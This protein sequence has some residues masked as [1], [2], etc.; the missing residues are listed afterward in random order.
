M[1][2]SQQQPNVPVKDTNVSKGQEKDT[3]KAAGNASANASALVKGSGKFTI[4]RVRDKIDA[5]PDID[6]ER[7]ASLKA[8]IKSGEYQ[9]DSL[10]L[11]NRILKSSILE[12][13]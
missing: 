13:N 6:I 12:D 2:I 3:G 7:V 5:A 11:S 10:R 8:R 4:D 9:I 1:K